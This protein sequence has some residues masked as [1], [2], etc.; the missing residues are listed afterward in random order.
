MGIKK[1]VACAA[2]L[3]CG[4][5]TTSALAETSVWK[6]SKGDN[7]FYLGGTFHLLSPQDYP[8]PEEFKQAYN[9]ST[10]LVFETD[11]IAA[12]SPDF[13]AKM[14]SAMTFSDQRTLKSELKPEVYERLKAFMTTRNLPIEQFSKLQPWGVSLVLA[15]VEYQRMGMTPEYGVDAFFN[16]LALSDSKTVLSLETPEEQLKFMSSMGDVEPNRS[17]DYT[18]NDIELMPEFVKKMKQCW[19]TGELDSMSDIEAIALM[20]KQ[21][22]EIYDTLVTKR[23]NNWMTQL[24]GFIKDDPKEFVLVG[25]LHLDGKEGLLTQL[26]QQ[27]FQVT[28]L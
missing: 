15:M 13:Q 26:K 22:P 10:K 23:N 9:D 1:L 25:A 17:V 6:V 7:Y 18:L 2:L 11:L 8:L 3:S 12:Q 4:I 27:G 24:P 14:M 19:R 21:F 5:F 28:Q 20:E 16:K